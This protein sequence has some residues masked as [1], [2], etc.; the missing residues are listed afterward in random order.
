METTLDRASPR[1]GSLSSLHRQPSGSYSP[2]SRVSTTSSNGSTVNIKD[3]DRYTRYF[4]I[5]AVQVIVQSRINVSERLK[6]ECKPSGNDWFNLN[7][8][9]VPEISERT[10]SALETESLSIKND[11]RVCCEVSLKTNDGVRIV[12]EHW[13]IS[14]RCLQNSNQRLSSGSPKN[15]QTASRTSA[16]LLTTSSNGIGPLS[17]INSASS[18]SR[19]RPNIPG[20]AMRTRL[21]SIDDCTGDNN[22]AANKLLMG[23]NNE[24]LDIKSSTSCFSLTTASSN[25]QNATYDQNNTIQG[26]PSISSLSYNNTNAHGQ[27]N[28]SASNNSRTPATT[29]TTQSQASKTSAMSSIY[30]IYNRM[31]LLLKTLMTT[32]HIVPAYR[33]SSRH[34]QS[35]SCALC[36]RVYASPLP[37]HNTQARGSIEDINVTSDSPN[38]R[39]LSSNSSFGS[40]NIREFVGP[41]DIEHFCPLLKLGSLKTEVNQLDLSICYRTDLR[42]SS[43]LIKS[44]RSKEMYNRILD[45]DCITAAKQLLAGHDVSLCG[46]SKDHQGNCHLNGQQQCKNENALNH[47]DKPLEAAFASNDTQK[48]DKT[49]LDPTL[50][51]MESAFDKLLEKSVANEDDLVGAANDAINRPISNTDKSSTRQTNGAGNAQSEPIQVPLNSHKSKYPDLYP[52]SG[53]TPKSLTDSFV[54]VDLNPPFASEEQ[55]EINSF[56]HGPKPTFNQG[57]DSLKDVDE[58]T[59]QLA[60]IEANASQL[61]DFVDNICASEDEESEK[62]SCSLG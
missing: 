45:E 26:S 37:Y 38:R 48:V 35:D 57:F 27:T 46:H 42:S 28:P 23:A 60:V 34:F 19:V 22:I 50:V 14:N 3:L 11:W 21:N 58:L 53:S 31:S 5:K 15:Y 25:N 12:L 24:N 9:D 18:S 29:A 51:I 44:P 40:I 17:A 36:Y 32:T 56:F 52:S 1:R 6:T 43:N 30:T 62:L 47:S 20:N 16:N 13:I 55:N 59:N 61:D 10:K 2:G 7:I 8:T 39:S 4:I 49:T 33:L 41:D 54:F